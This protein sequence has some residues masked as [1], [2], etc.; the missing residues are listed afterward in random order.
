MRRQ[1]GF[2]L[3]ELMTVVAIVA[4]VA[5]VAYPSYQ[6][7]V[8]KSRRKTATSCLLE[9]AHYME[10]FYTTNMRYDKA[11]DGTAV[12]LPSTQCGTDLAGHYTISLT[13]TTSQTAYTVQAVPQGQQATRD[14]K[15][16][17]LTLNQRGEKGESGTGTVTD[18]W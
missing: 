5:A 1:A 12:A 18:C 14:T 15:C 8:V 4:I 10:R 17:T 11:T 7:S 3:V 16:G 9:A 6:D 2:S 13:D